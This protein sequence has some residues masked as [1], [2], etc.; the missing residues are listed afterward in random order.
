MHCFR[1]LD[2][3][4]DKM[5]G[6]FE[7]WKTIEDIKKIFGHIIKKNAVQGLDDF[8]LCQECLFPFKGACAVSEVIM[9]KDRLLKV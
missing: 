4:V 6:L 9:L 3:E 1:F 5:E 2:L 7:S 8:F